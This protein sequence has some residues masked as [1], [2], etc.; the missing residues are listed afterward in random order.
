MDLKLI[1]KKVSQ[2]K[3]DL[4]SHAHKERQIEDISV[5]EIEKTILKGVIIEKYLKDPR[6]QSC[7]LVTKNLHIT[8]LNHPLGLIIEPEQR[9]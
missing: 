1:R 7:L 9:S 6:G 5:V 8:D 3:Y 2:G 4:S